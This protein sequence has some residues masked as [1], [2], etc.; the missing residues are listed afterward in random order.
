MTDL[1]CTQVYEYAC[2]DADIT[3]RLFEIFEKELTDLNL[4]KLFHE[5]EMPLIR[6]LMDM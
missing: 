2:E 3:Y 6:V 1:P 4:D 5:M